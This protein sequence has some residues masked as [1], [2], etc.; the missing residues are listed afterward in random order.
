MRD[1]RTDTHASVIDRYLHQVTIARALTPVIDDIFNLYMIVASSCASS[2]P[3]IMAMAMYVCAYIDQDVH[4]IRI[5]RPIFA[6]ELE[7]DP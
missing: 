2:S 1:M 5:E 4:P 6:W 7:L 3:I